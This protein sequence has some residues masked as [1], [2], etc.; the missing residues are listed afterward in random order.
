MN[1]KHLNMIT[2]I[3]TT[4]E[5]P[6]FLLLVHELDQDLAIRNGESNDFFAQFNKV[7]LIQH[8]IVLYFDGI[9]VGC[10]AIKAYDEHSMEVKRMYVKP[11]QR[12]KGLAG[13]VLHELE[14]WTRE[15]GYVSCVLETGV[16]Q[17]EAIR[18]Y[19]KSGYERIPNYGQYAGI[20]DS[21]CFRKQLQHTQHAS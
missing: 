10:G 13:N 2:L 14:Q 9:P 19:S 18:L 6:D 5:H 17:P 15:L 12:G 3:R 16:K 21:V 4:S 1:A 7:N 11:D 8:T 20:E